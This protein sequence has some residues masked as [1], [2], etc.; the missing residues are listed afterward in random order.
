MGGLGRWIRALQAP[1][2]SPATCWGLSRAGVSQSPLNTFNPVPAPAPP[3][4]PHPS[5]KGE[6]QVSWRPEGVRRRQLPVA[7]PCVLSPLPAQKSQAGGPEP[8]LAVRVVGPHCV[9][10][11]LSQHLKI[12]SF[13]IKSR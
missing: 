3:P 4:R 6:H 5:G 13:H 11:N 12:R 2:G 7:L 1:C 8:H 10:K 9:F